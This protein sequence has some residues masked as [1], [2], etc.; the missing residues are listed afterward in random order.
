MCLSVL[1]QEEECEPGKE[2]REVVAPLCVPCQEAMR[3][4]EA[5]GWRRYKQGEGS[6]TQDMCCPLDHQRLAEAVEEVG[7]EDEGGGGCL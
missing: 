4:G 2:R 6:A 3:E 5:G 7:G 1:L